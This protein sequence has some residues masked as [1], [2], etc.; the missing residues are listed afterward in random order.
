VAEPGGVLGPV[1][2]VWI[3]GKFRPA[4]WRKSVSVVSRLVN[5]LAFSFVPGPFLPLI[6]ILYSGEKADSD[7]KILVGI[8]FL[9]VGAGFSGH[10]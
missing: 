9:E 3:P 10:L 2:I 6:V 8:I 5:L 7:R 1:C 4:I